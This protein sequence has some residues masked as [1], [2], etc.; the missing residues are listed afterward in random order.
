MTNFPSD[1][2]T[3]LRDIDTFE[4]SL[5]D[6]AANKWKFLLVKSE[7]TPEPAVAL[8][9][10]HAL[11]PA[12]MKAA[13]SVALILDGRPHQIRSAT[14][15]V[16][17]ELLAAC[18]HEVT[19]G[20][21][22]KQTP[23]PAVKVEPE[24]APVVVTIDPVVVTDAAAAAMLAQS[25]RT[26][27]KLKQDE[28]DQAVAAVIASAQ[29]DSVEA[30]IAA[31]LQAHEPQV[32]LDAIQAIIQQ[33]QGEAATQQVEIL[34]RDLEVA[35]AELDAHIALSAHELATSVTVARAE[36]AQAAESA[37][38][39][40]RAALQ[41]QLTAMTKERDDALAKATLVAADLA[42]ARE[43]IQQSS[44][45]RAAV[46]YVAQLAKQKGKTAPSQVLPPGETL[47][48]PGHDPWDFD[49]AG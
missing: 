2:K 19:E 33:A 17:L 23:E 35:R 12:L 43:T 28:T 16:A 41:A 4:V 42:K 18:G 46:A 29:S 8:G 15:R 26:L 36:A 40:E 49:N 20:P 30:I 37:Y 39:T 25:E 13:Q 34:R 21:A 45:S 47:A 38:A 10:D 6:R 14:Q 27:A 11:R 24:V 1:A 22:T 48:G 9:E 44:A 32:D 7:G 3:E 5:V 31:A